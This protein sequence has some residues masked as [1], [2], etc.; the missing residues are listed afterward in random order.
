MKYS[1]DQIL[2][3]KAILENLETK[4]KRIEKK[5]N[6]PQNIKEGSIVIETENGLVLSEKEELKRREKLR[7]KIKKLKQIGTEVKHE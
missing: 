3:S 4:D 6:L 2:E 1:I 7:K 5:K